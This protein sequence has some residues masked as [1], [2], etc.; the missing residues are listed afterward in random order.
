[1]NQRERMLAIAVGAMAVMIVGYFSYESL[2]SSLD[3]RSRSVSDAESQLESKAKKLSQAKRAVKRL[4]E[5]QAKSLPSDGE[6][7][8]SLYQ[9]W[10]LERLEKAGFRDVK[11]GVLGARS[12]VDA[13]QLHTFNVGCR[14]N[15][16]QLTVFLHELYSVDRL[17][18]VRRLSLKPIP[19]TKD[20]DVGFTV[21]A[22][23]LKGADLKDRL[24]DEPSHRLA[25]G[26]LDDY[27]RV[28]VGRNL[29]ASANRPP[30]LSSVSSQRG[31]PNLSLKFGVKAE[32]PDKLDQVT[33]S[34]ANGGPVG[35][36]IDPK[37]GEF[38]WT[39]KE[40]GEYT[41]TVVATDNGLPARSVSTAVKIAV[42]DPP[43]PPKP[44]PPM[45]KKLDFDDAKFTFV[46][47]ILDVG[48]TWEVWLTI[49]T[50]GEVKKLH[51]GDKLAIGSIEGKIKQVAANR[52]E[53]ETPEQRF[54]VSLGD[55]LLQGRPLAA[56]RE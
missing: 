48:G 38:S 26:S 39:P 37:T 4:K 54:E 22:L 33:Y 11:L 43:P 24:S 25:L 1:M 2:S 3:A 56:E 7:A 45:K 42:T 20:L 14:G 5:Y 21:E 16:K 6:L 27:E 32:D 40:K 41:A 30:R 55:N 17:Q 51:E 47:A 18:R 19:D 12:R 29:F 15:L 35:A 44:E 52:V 8:R 9:N 50:S 31:Y 10:L 23:S 46:T 28:I 34:L 49:R 36:R 53:I 13:F